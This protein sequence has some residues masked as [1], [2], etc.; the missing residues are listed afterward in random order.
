[1]D[2]KETLLNCAEALVRTRG[3]DAFSYADLAQEVG[4][5]KASIHYHFATKADLAAQLIDRYSTEFLSRLQ[6][7]SDR[8]KS[9]ADD[10][11]AYIDIYR[12]A[13][14]A[15]TRLCLCVSFGATRDSLD[16]VTQAHLTQFH[17]DSLTWLT[18]VWEKAASDGSVRGSFASP[19]DEAH[20]TLALVEGAQ[21]IA[22][23][24]ASDQRFERAVSPLLGR[25]SGHIPN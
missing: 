14:G 11:G 5:R 23:A 25:L 18:R 24:T 12:E 3:F 22:R 17:T 2:T 21:L 15:G 6:A 4:I 10:L 1:M 9:A 20:A 7:I 16:D 8:E 13:L 19:E